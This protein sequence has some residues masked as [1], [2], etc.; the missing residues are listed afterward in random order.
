M[1]RVKGRSDTA[2]DLEQSQG[3]ALMAL[4]FLAEDATRLSRFLALTGIGPAE[5][6]ASAGAPQ[7]LAAVLEHIV[8]DESLLLVF[9]AAKSVPAQS[10]EPARALL[11]KAART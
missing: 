4:A 5:L 3:I 6:R 10:I 8:G 7:T 1:G 2:E 9:S 11:A